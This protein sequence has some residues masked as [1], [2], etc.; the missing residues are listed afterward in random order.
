[1]KQE[2]TISRGPINGG[3]ICSRDPQMR[4]HDPFQRNLPES[5]KIITSLARNR[6]DDI[7]HLAISSLEQA[8]S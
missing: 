7:R 6:A 1:M 4:H 2:W 8:L 5:M 3:G